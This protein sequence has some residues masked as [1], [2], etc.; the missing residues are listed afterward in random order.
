M[1][2]DGSLLT[3]GSGNI[4]D[5]RYFR[6]SFYDITNSLTKDFKIPV[7]GINP[8]SIIG[9]NELGKRKPQ[10]AALSRGTIQSSITG[11]KDYTSKSMFFSKGNVYSLGEENALKLEAKNIKVEKI[12]GGATIATR[13]LDALRKM[14]G[15]SRVTYDEYTDEDGKVVSLLGKI[16]RGLDIGFDDIDANTLEEIGATE[17]LNPNTWIAKLTGK[18]K[19][20]GFLRPNKGLKAIDKS[21]SGI[22]RTEKNYTEMFSDL[23][24]DAIEKEDDIYIGLNKTYSLMDLYK[25]ISKDKSNS[26]ELAKKY[27]WQ[28]NAG[29][30]SLKDVTSKSTGIHFLFDRVNST[31]GVGGLGLS[32]D[33][34]GRPTDIVQN[35]MLKRA[36]PVYLGYNAL[37]FGIMLTEGEEDENGNRNNIVKSMARTVAEA[38]LM[39]RKGADMVG[40][41]DAFDVINETFQGIDQIE[42]LPGI[43]MLQLDQDFEERVDYYN[44]GYEKVRKNRFWDSG[45]QAFTGQKIDYY[46]P[47][48]YRRIMADAEFSDSK[49]G[50]RWEYFSNAPFPTPLTP[51]APIKHFLTDPYHYDKKHANDRPYPITTPLFQNVPFVGG[52]LSNTIGEVLKPTKYT[53]EHVINKHGIDPDMIGAP[54]GNALMFDASG[55]DTGTFMGVDEGLSAIPM[56][57]VGAGGGMELVGGFSDVGDM[58][59]G[60]SGGQ[61]SM[62]SMSTG[63]I[64]T[65]YGDSNLSSRGAGTQ[66]GIGYNAG[67]MYEDAGNFFGLYG[68]MGTT[69]TGEPLDNMK[70]LENGSYAYGASRLWW[71]SESGGLGGDINE[72]GRRFLKQRMADDNLINPV[73]N[74]M[75]DWMPSSDYFTDFTKGDP[76]VK[77]ASGELRLPGE[78]YERLH[79]IKEFDLYKFDA[80]ALGSVEE[81]LNSTFNKEYA[82]IENTRASMGAGDTKGKHLSNLR[83]NGFVVDSGAEIS[84][85]DRN[86]TS[87]YD[88]L[89]KSDSASGQGMLFVRQV[90]SLSDIKG[91]DGDVAKA[92]FSMYASGIDSA[93]LQYVDN[94]GNVS[95]M[96]EVKF[97]NSKIDGYM[98]NMLKAREKIDRGIDNGTLSKS[99]MYAPID[100]LR[101]LADVAPYS[102]EYRAM[103]TKV[104][105]M[106]LSED[107]REEVNGIKERAKDVRKPLRTYNYKFKG[108]GTDK[109]KKVIDTVLSPNS[110]TVV[111]DDTVYR[112]AGVQLK[113]QEDPLMM[114]NMEKLLDDFLYV[115]SAVTLEYDKNKAL[116]A[117]GGSKRVIVHKGVKTLQG[118]L[119][120]NEFAEKS[121]G[122]DP[123]DTRVHTNV[124][125]RVVGA[126]WESFAHM[127]TPFHS[128]FLRVR[129]AKEDYER[130]RVYGIKKQIVA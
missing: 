10:F 86:I 87:S 1:K 20:S 68:F 83:E 24:S 82:R 41:S 114:S 79:N 94:K 59:E 15:T 95:N 26:K 45:N 92:N 31:L 47:N 80:G 51:F 72:I 14:Q 77:I 9:L 100:R 122:S 89:I 58:Y 81:I 13:E 99:D 101:I 32:V 17:W 98:N 57:T 84:D 4:S 54:V 52:F 49:W 103:Q 67:Q 56:V 128:K 71:D 19:D 3:D 11:S 115:G 37:Q 23:M 119:L 40:I 60:L 44:N 33:S 105:T 75:A 112:L 53:H 90:D 129:S 6:N 109:Q 110:F 34:L 36:L 2:V 74:N 127:D 116:R 126:M 123:I 102:D 104:A 85:Y 96:E 69:V 55:F 64:S 61:A 125:Q 108:Q 22:V 7:I 97:D 106:D 42:E 76:Y 62:S 28:F 50:S 25:D 43:R 18:M 88:A 121:E 78:A 12:R 120:D 70:V 38:D 29:R 65:S 117:K 5:L 48:L 66:N 63:N 130:S 107:E 21:D 30:E 73:S 27:V 39:F 91:K 8:F 111:G 124:G 118:E 46:R 93:Y 113:T 35:L 16:G